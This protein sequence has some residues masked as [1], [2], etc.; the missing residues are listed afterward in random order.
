M[1][2][3][4]NDLKEI[5]DNTV[6]KEV[7]FSEKNKENVRSS[8]NQ[9][10][11][12]KTILL[13]PIFMN[14]ISI[15]LTCLFLIGS[16]Y[17]LVDKLDLFSNEEGLATNAT[18]K[19]FSNGA[20]DIHIDKNNPDILPSSEYKTVE[21]FI[22]SAKYELN[23]EPP[24]FE[25]PSKELWQLDV[26]RWITDYAKHF[27]A[28]S[29]DKEEIKLLQNIEEASLKIFKVGDPIEPKENQEKLIINLNFALDE[30]ITKKIK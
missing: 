18:D 29:T 22:L 16:G 24:S 4:F 17:Y 25:D 5:M 30:F 19:D 7:N 23:S 6:L 10:T 21:E 9:T 1:N 28:L 12:K 27:A 26:A 14:I 15:S 8:L 2:H 11:S 13:K 20:L 3:I